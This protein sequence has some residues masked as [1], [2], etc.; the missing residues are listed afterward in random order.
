MIILLWSARE[1]YFG[2]LV[3]IF[4]ALVKRNWGT[5][6]IIWGARAWGALALGQNDSIL[7]NFQDGS[8]ASHLE[9]NRL[10]C[11]LVKKFFKDRIGTHPLLIF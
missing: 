1:R 8:T 7:V 11:P 3:N 6:K 9:I 10:C 2:A 4:G 5:L